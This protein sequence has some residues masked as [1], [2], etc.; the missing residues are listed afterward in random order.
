MNETNW[1]PGIVV[2]GGG[3]VLAALY[4]LASR[5]KAAAKPK[6]GT[7]EDLDQRAQ[8]LIEQL[9]ELNAD[10]H[11]LSD[12]QFAAETARLESE[13]AAALR[14]RDEHRKGGEKTKEKEAPAARAA[15]GRA[16]PAGFFA[17][18]PELKGA[19]WGGGVVS[20]VVALGLLLSQSTKER[21]DDETMTGKDPNEVAGTRGAGQGQQGQHPQQAEMD[22][23]F[24]AALE[25]VKKNPEN[26]EAAAEVAHTLIWRQSWD[27]AASI[28]ERSL[29]LDPFHVESRIHRAAIDASRGD[30]EG[31]IK[32]LE[33]LANTL[34]DAHEAL[35]FIGMIAMQGGDNERALESF[36]RF[37]AD[38]PPAEQPPQLLDGIAMLRQQL[39]IKR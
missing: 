34:P 24:Q 38:A 19:L 17:R 31:A 28:T 33:H 16:A 37:A 10:R 32:Q 2:L 4:L 29:S 35:L 11:H 14:A 20:F 12:A 6:D 25:E 22:R 5:K 8:S 27:E 15:S 9:R 26:L 18:H 36:E 3:L 7:L 30:V 23:M 39:G 21:R 13:A 1:L